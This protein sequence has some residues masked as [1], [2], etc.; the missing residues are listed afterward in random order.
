[1]EQEGVEAKARVS[2]LGGSILQD[3]KNLRRQVWG[4]IMSLVWGFCVGGTRG[5]S[6]GHSAVHAGEGQEKHKLHCAWAGLQMEQCLY[7]FI[8]HRDQ[9]IGHHESILPCNPGV[10]LVP[11]LVEGTLCLHSPQCVITDRC[12][13]SPKPK[14]ARRQ[15]VNEASSSIPLI[16]CKSLLPDHSL[17]TCN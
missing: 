4:K 7:Y 6:S 2:I 12:L 9:S 5:E 15:G 17:S 1:M 14:V 3:L 8:Y 11:S 16:D 13:L 10:P